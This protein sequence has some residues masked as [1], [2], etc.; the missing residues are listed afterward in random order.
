MHKRPSARAPRLQRWS[1]EEDIVLADAVREQAPWP[2]IPARIKDACGTTRTTTACQLRWYH[3]QEK[4]RRVQLDMHTADDAAAPV[5]IDITVDGSLVATVR[6]HRTL[7]EV[8]LY[9]TDNLEQDPAA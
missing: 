9:L 1:R 7:R 3:I 2:D 6:S 5:T 4:R 8:L